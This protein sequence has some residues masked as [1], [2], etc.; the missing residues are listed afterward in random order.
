MAP[1]VLIALAAAPAPQTIACPAWTT[2][3]VKP[4]LANFFGDQ[5]ADALRKDGFTVIT[6]AEITTLIGQQRQAELTGCNEQSQSCLAELS[7]ALG[8]DLTLTGSVAR[9]DESFEVRL[10]IV[11]AM[12]AKVIAETTVSAKGQTA[13]LP[14]LTAAG[15]RLAQ[16]LHPGSVHAEPSRWTAWLTVGGGVVIAGL[17]A[18]LLV[19]ASSAYQ[20]LSNNLMKYDLATVQ[21]KVNTGS[22]LQTGGWVCVGIGAAALVTG[23]V[24]LFMPPSSMAPVVSMGPTGA[25][26]GVAGAF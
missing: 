19:G 21:Q 15:H 8:A 24:M 25:S 16:Q 12:T 7:Q 5:V 14:E 10:K 26:V 2:I 11:R 22:G 23:V 20:D 1:L 9:L 4:E 17:G 13:L 18:A 6:N 3:D